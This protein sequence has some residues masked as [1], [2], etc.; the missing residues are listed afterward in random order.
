MKLWFRPLYLIRT[1]P[2]LPG[3]LNALEVT[4]LPEGSH[5]PELTGGWGDDS[6][7]LDDTAELPGDLQVSGVA[8][9]ATQMAEWAAA[10][11]ERQMHRTVVLDIWARGGRV[12]ARRWTQEDDGLVLH[13]E[14]RRPP[15]R[16]VAVR[17][18]V[19]E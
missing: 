3:R 11:M 1:L 14:G 5:G 19:R 18:L 10:W 15:R 17:T 7:P 16:G 8:A 13:R 2:D 9:D 4:Y 12:I 6:H